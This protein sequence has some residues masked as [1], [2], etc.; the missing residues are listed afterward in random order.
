MPRLADIPEPVCHEH[1]HP[2]RPCP[3]PSADVKLTP[4][5]V[6]SRIRVTP[7]N[8]TLSSDGSDKDKEGAGLLSL[9]VPQIALRSDKPNVLHAFSPQLIDTMSRPIGRCQCD[10]CSINETGSGAKSEHNGYASADGACSSQLAQHTTVVGHQPPPHT[11]VTLLR[12]RTSSPLSLSFERR[13]EGPK[14]SADRPLSE[15]SDDG[16]NCETVQEA[17]EYIPTVTQF[18]KTMTNRDP[19]DIHLNFGK[20]TIQV[21]TSSSSVFD[22]SRPTAARYC[23]ARTPAATTSGWQK[24]NN[25]SDGSLPD[26]DLF[27]SKT[28]VDRRDPL[29]PAEM[30]SYL[31]NLCPSAPKIPKL[32]ELSLGCSTVDLQ[33]YRV[34]E[35]DTSF[36]LGGWENP[37]L[38]K[39]D[40]DVERGKSERKILIPNRGAPLRRDV[41]ENCGMRESPTER[42]LLS[43]SRQ[44][45]LSDDGGEDPRPIF[46]VGETLN[47]CVSSKVTD[48]DDDSEFRMNTDVDSTVGM[49]G[50]NVVLF[51]PSPIS[52]VISEKVILPVTSPRLHKSLSC[53]NKRVFNGL[54]KANS[55]LKT[56]MKKEMNQQLECI[57]EVFLLALFIGSLSCLIS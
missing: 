26:F 23:T 33:C 28:L 45:F 56:V 50:P 5:S 4:D 15:S 35:T 43:L 29:T 46:T 8:H 52:T 54:N 55:L 42:M 14:R 30:E 16:S 27:L 6:P 22:V 20:P 51:T 40:N 9:A 12:R 41:S 3:N 2:S 11:G 31:R 21:S 19:G 13:A 32:K 1:R 24:E 34:H 53:P 7:R 18:A 36:S 47:G 39:A 49:D 17:G 10:E 48:I 44:L 57:T 37:T 25:D 38:H